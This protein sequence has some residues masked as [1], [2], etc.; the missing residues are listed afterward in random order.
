VAVFLKEIIVD[1]VLAIPSLAASV[2]LIFI[3]TFQM[4]QDLELLRHY[5]LLFL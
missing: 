5:L 3:G 2:K 1:N 4:R